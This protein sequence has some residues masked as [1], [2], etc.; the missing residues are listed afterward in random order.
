MFDVCINGLYS[1][2]TIDQMYKMYLSIIAKT[3]H[4]TTYPSPRDAPDLRRLSCKVEN[5]PIC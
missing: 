4:L 5:G 1:V 2:Q 3:E